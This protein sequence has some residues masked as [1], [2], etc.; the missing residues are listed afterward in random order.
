MEIKPKWI[1]NILQKQS[2]LARLGLVLEPFGDQG[3]LVKE[4]PAALGEMDIKHCIESLAEDIEDWDHTLTIESLLQHVFSTF[5]CHSSIRAGR[6]LQI[7]EMNALL[8]DMERLPSTGQ[9]NHGRPTY[10]SL[11][12]KDIESLFGR[13]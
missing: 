6:R 4:T 1:D 13:T 11:A 10:V 12:R 7:D 2:D 3:I 9:C 8:R 5:A